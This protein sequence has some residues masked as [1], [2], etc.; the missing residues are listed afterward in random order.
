MIAYIQTKGRMGC[1]QYIFLEE[2]SVKTA[3]VLAARPVSER[4]RFRDIII[5][6]TMN[7]E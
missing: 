4:Q 1:E 7:T 2:N 3:R 6:E 5:I